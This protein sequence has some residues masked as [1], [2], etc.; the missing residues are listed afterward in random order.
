MEVPWMPSSM[1]WTNRSAILSVLG[2]RQ[3]GADLRCCEKV[4]AH[5]V[6]GDVSSKPLDSRCSTRKSLL[7]LLV[8]CA[9][10]VQPSQGRLRLPKFSGKTYFFRS[11]YGF[12]QI[13]Y[14]LFAFVSPLG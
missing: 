4:C 3:N 13:G 8:F 10:Q 2:I 9:G 14:R 7:G 6:T 11:R 12:P 5:F 1:S